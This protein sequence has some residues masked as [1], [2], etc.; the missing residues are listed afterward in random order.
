MRVGPETHRGT[1]RRRSA[2]RNCRIARRRRM[3]TYLVG[4]AVRDQ[5][6]GRVAPERDWVVVGGTP[7]EMRKRGF[8]QV[9]RDFPVFLHPDTGDEYALART[10]R[11]TGPGHA[12]FACDADPSV[13]LEEDLLRRDLTV[14]A[15]AWDGTEYIDPYGGRKDNRCP[16][17]ASCL[18][19]VP[20]RSAAGV[21]GGAVRGRATRVH[22]ER[23]DPR[24]HGSDGAGTGGVVPA[25]GFGRSSRRPCQR[26][27]RSASSPCYADWVAAGGS[28]ASIS[29]QPRRC[30]RADPSTTR[31]PPSQRSAGSTSRLPSERY[32]PSCAHPA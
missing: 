4:G 28:T 12:D 30:S 5:L 6:L 29:T 7:A 8:R 19:R 21:P 3:K 18:A 14:N 26:R 23:G 1:P 24:T 22:G 25:S 10:E 32:T 11:R 9:G 20:R 27:V 2:V 16:G 17:A 13:T 15:I 31:T